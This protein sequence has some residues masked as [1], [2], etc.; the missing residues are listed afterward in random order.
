MSERWL[1]GTPGGVCSLGLDVVSRLKCSR[2]ILG[3]RVA[4]RLPE[5]LVQIVGERG[6][7]IAAKEVM[8]DHAHVFV[9]VGPTGVPALL[10]REFKGRAARMLREEFS[11]L[12]RFARVYWSY[13]AASVGYAS[14]STACRYIEHQWDVVAS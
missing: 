10:V 13:F 2:R 3:G 9:R 12:H 11:H 6:W 4:R 1:R 7:Q 5:L 14:E 8:P